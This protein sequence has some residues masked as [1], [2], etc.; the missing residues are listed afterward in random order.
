MKPYFIHSF[1]S[2]QQTGLAI[3]NTGAIIDASKVEED[4]LAR[5]LC[6]NRRYDSLFDFKPQ[7]E[8]FNFLQFTS[9][10]LLAFPI[11]LY[12]RKKIRK[13][14]RLNY[15]LQFKELLQVRNN[16]E[17]GSFA[18]D[19][20]LFKQSGF[21]LLKNKTHLANL[22]C[23][24]I[25]FGD[26]FIDGIACEHGK[27]NIQQIL[28]NEQLNYYLKYKKTESGFCLFYEFDICDVLPQEVLNTVNNKYGI[29]YKSFYDH[30]QFLLQ[31][32]NS[33]LNKLDH[34]KAEAAAMLICKAC[35]KCFDTYK[36]DINGFDENYSL[37]DLMQ[38]QKTKD[39]DII[40]VLLAL[41]AVLIDKNQDHFKQQFSSWSS[42]VR[43]MQLYDD[44]QDVAV[45]CDF[46]M[47]V[48]CFFAKKYFKNEWRW[49]Q[50]N[51]L[52]LQ[53]IKGIQLHADIVFNMPASCMMAMQYARN[54]AHTEL[55]WV[56]RKIQNYLWRK[57]WLGFDNHLL[58][59]NV[60]AIR[61]I[62]L[63][64]AIL[65]LRAIQYQV[66][67]INQHMI[68]NDMKLAHIIDIALM[69]DTLKNYI[70]SKISHKEKYMLT[71]CYIEF[72]LNQKAALVKKLAIN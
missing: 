47:N 62:N 33:F 21:Q 19:T 44:M 11:G 26:E 55:S 66:M 50:E 15:I 53:Q 12:M 36:A 7:K 3:S 43:S 69:N 57:N 34:K 24:A 30:L 59:E 65:N 42:M 61:E 60:N 9:S 68:S 5:L 71:N 35:N 63:N 46:Q 23:L 16:I 27:Q 51:K 8:L 72:P 37:K 32:M 48:L 31:E 58:N 28:N 25:L 1:T 49:L 2:V 70:F 52:Q 67:N 14:E 13:N 45:D 41:R 54:I 29:T 22:V 38:Y 18:Y 20:I 56:Q 17:K 40:Q 39:D 6:E 64:D 10:M 4:A